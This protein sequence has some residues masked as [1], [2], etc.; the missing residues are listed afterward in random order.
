[1]KKYALLFMLM[2]FMQHAFAGKPVK[3]WG[4]LQ[5]ISTQLC[6]QYGRPVVLRG[7]SLGWHNIWPRF[8]N[9]GAVKALATDW[10]ANVIR[11]AMG[12]K[13]EDNYL[14]NP[15]FAKQCVETV[16]KAA[17]KNNVY[18]IM[19]WHAHETYTKEAKEWFGYF[20]K[21]YGKHPHII[22]EIFN[23]PV[24]QSWESLKEYAREVITEI[25]K[26]DPDNVILVGCPHWD[27]DIDVV[28]ASPL[29]GFTN[30][31]YTVHFYAATHGS[32]LRNK[33]VEAHKTLPIFVSECA[34]MEASGNGPLNYPE[35]QQWIDTME[36]ERISWVNWSVSDKDE[37]CSMLLPRAK[38]DGQ[39]PEDVIKEYG[40][41][42]KSNLL[43]YNK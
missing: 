30:I 14:E 4:K 13:I 24:N 38:A 29:T 25:R 27:Q 22:Y 34:G 39:W 21:K 8:Y 3:E 35:W 41:K 7:V 37:T 42:V 32:Y 1:M 9:K 19:D 36:R 5:V 16:V 43:K 33:M 23:E 2:L 10:H 15:S 26:Y 18:V 40:K 20:A 6:D 31:M 28:A 11:A 17:I 12:I